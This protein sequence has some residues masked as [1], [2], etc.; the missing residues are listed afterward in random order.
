MVYAPVELL[1]KT[2]H[3]AR[4][5]EERSL[6]QSLLKYEAIL[7]N[8]SI[9]IAFTR[10]QRFE[11]VNPRFEQMLGW[12]R[13]ALVGQPGHVIW[14]SRQ[15]HAAI[16]AFVGPLLARGSEFGD[17]A[18]ECRHER[19]EG[20]WRD[21]SLRRLELP[22]GEVEAI[23]VTLD[24]G[25]RDLD[26]PA[27][28][29]A[30]RVEQLLA[31]HRRT[32]VAQYDGG[33]VL[34]SLQIPERLGEECVGA[35]LD[36]GHPHEA[37]LTEQRGRGEREQGSLYVIVSADVGDFETRVFGA[38]VRTQA[39]GRPFGAHFFRARYE[40]DGCGLRRAPRH[41]RNDRTR[42][43][44]GTTSAGG[45]AAQPTERVRRRVRARA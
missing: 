32:R 43:R 9:G 30:D 4:L 38:Q 26:S 12:P 36:T 41:L 25:T 21:P 2:G 22:R 42:R 11:Q 7:E 40:H 10:D 17:V 31:A 19:A 45:H 28:A 35:L 34:G 24:R 3:D 39:G 6:R 15:E 37:R 33:A 44:A 16:G 18:G 1:A 5:R 13:A 8:A 20:L 27:R 29:R 14:R 23:G